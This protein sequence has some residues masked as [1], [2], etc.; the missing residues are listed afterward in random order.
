LYANFTAQTSYMVT[1]IQSCKKQWNKTYVQNETLRDALDGYVDTQ[2][3]FVRQIMKNVDV[4]FD[5]TSKQV[6]K[7]FT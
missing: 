1:V 5:L 3:A 2:T 4:V 6:G 7:A